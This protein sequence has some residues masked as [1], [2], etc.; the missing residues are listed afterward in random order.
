MNHEDN[1]QPQEIRKKLKHLE[2]D[3]ESKKLVALSER[4]NRQLTGA[5]RNNTPLRLA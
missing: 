5:D 4:L 2:R 1:K 3:Q